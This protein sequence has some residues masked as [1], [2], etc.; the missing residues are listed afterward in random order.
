MLTSASSL[1]ALQ[2][3]G[4]VHPWTS[5]YVLVQLFIGLGL[6]VVLA[7]WEWK[8]AKNPVIPFRL[9]AGQRVVTFTFL[10]AFIVGINY[11]VI[12]TIGPEVLLEVF[13]PK[14]VTGGLYGLGPSLCL[15]LGA[16]L[17]NI[18]LTVFGGRARELLFVAAVIMS[19][20]VALDTFV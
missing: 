4:S 19:K 7:L 16:T 2:S 12:L 9:F 13:D 20:L 15:M 8:G 11:Y 18:L 14:P 3:G 1:V 10:I 6:L 5:A 17:V